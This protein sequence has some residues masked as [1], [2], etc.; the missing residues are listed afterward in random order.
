MSKFG[1]IVTTRAFFP[2]FLALDAREIVLRR[3]KSMGHQAVIIDEDATKYGAVES[4]DDA[5][6]CAELFRNHRYEIDGIIVILPN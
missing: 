3:L 2:G 1:V 6:K 4:Y 5:A